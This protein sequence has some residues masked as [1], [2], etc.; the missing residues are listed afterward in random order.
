[1]IRSKLNPRKQYLQIALNSTLNEA[2]AIISQLPIS[3]RIIIEAGT[4]LIKQYGIS[5]ITQL[6]DWW[7]A[8]LSGLPLFKSPESNEFPVGLKMIIDAFK[9]AKNKT[10]SF[11][12]K[13]NY[14]LSPYIVADLKTMDRGQTEVELAAQAGASAAVALGVAP[15]PTLE[16]FIAACENNGL[17]SM[18][19]MM[20]VEFALSVLRK[21][22]K[23]PQVVIIHRGVDEESFK[24]PI[25]YHEITRIKGQFDILLSLAGGDTIREVQAAVFNDA[26]IV[27]VWKSFYQKTND[28]AQLSENFLKEIR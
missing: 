21:L 12:A 14:N 28:T 18:I 20:N 17:D 10:K 1:M 5:A 22:K 6:R 15:L 2:A 3:D 23:L 7:S 26:N 16:N 24:K 8:R 19:D 4:P 27:V 25:P 13:N 9:D 11:P